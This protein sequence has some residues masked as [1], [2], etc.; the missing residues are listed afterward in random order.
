ME[1][2]NICQSK[3]ILDNLKELRNICQLNISMS[4]EIFVN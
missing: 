4:L 1:L 3:N 2:Q